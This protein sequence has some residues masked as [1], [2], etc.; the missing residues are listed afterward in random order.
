MLDKFDPEEILIELKRTRLCKKC[1]KPDYLWSCV[2]GL[3]RRCQL[4]EMEENRE[5][6]EPKS[7]ERMMATFRRSLE[8]LP[9]PEHKEE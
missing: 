6:H 2:L 5:F 3:C 9:M 8:R 4:A 7:L 1:G